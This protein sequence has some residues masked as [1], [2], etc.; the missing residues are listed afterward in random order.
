MPA[1]GS[2]SSSA[3]TGS[4]APTWRMLSSMPGHGVRSMEEV[5]GGG[6]VGHRRGLSAAPALRRFSAAELSH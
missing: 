6:A 4:V 3:V 5:V 2:R 1:C